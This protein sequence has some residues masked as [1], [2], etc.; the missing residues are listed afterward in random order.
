MIFGNLGVTTTVILPSPLAGLADL[1]SERGLNPS[2]P[3]VLTLRA[4][5]PIIA[6][7]ARNKT[8][9]I[10]VLARNKTTARSSHNAK[11]RHPRFRVL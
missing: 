7:L 1:K 3:S 5:E 11:T 10:A 2:P 6:V 8:T 9:V 4:F